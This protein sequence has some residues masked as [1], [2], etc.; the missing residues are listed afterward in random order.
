[1]RE[2]GF[3][4][5]LCC[6]TGAAD[7]GNGPQALQ[8]AQ[9]QS[10]SGGEVTGASADSEPLL[11]SRGQAEL[12]VPDSAPA[13]G[14]SNH[15][16][17]AVELKGILKKPCE[18]RACEVPS[19]QEPWQTESIDADG[20]GNKKVS[21]EPMMTVYRIAPRN[22]SM[23]MKQISSHTHAHR[24]MLQSAAWEEQTSE[25]KVNTRKNSAIN[26]QGEKL[27][28]WLRSKAA[29]RAGVVPGRP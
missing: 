23:K 15:R 6:W 27:R 20:R 25:A 9:A 5:G 12:S 11:P 18:K 28:S 21:F 26:E 3:F 7:G 19:D 24:Q 16:K 8:Q 10:A 1:M 29:V 17:T 22:A 14:L 4:T 13:T 2:T